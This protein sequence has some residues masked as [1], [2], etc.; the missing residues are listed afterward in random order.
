MTASHLENPLDDGEPTLRG[1]HIRVSP[2]SPEDARVAVSVTPPRRRRVTVVPEQRPGY[3]SD[4]DEWRP[5]VP[6]L[7]AGDFRCLRISCGDGDSL[8]DGED[9]VIEEARFATPL[10]PKI[11]DCQQRNGD[12]G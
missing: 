8:W 11:V 9:P 3:G 4:D 7:R 6:L 12:D 5:V 1:G 10:K 2:L